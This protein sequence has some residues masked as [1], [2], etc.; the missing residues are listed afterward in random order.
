MEPFSN[1]LDYFGYSTGGHHP[2]ASNNTS[3]P[4][5]NDPGQGFPRGGMKDTNDPTRQ[6]GASGFENYDMPQVDPFGSGDP[7]LAFFHHL[8][9]MVSKDFP[10]MNVRHLTFIWLHGDVVLILLVI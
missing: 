6:Q 2:N 10:L 7:N 8:N 5:Y 9:S 1:F 4:Q 3:R